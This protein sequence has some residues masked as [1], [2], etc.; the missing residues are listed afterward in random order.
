MRG[1][2]GRCDNNTGIIRHTIQNYTESPENSVERVHNNPVHYSIRLASV[3]Y[4]RQG[5]KG[6]LHNN[7]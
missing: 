6:A 3:G 4:C 1:V 2:V 5:E 7:S